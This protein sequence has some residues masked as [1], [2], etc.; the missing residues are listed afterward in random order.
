MNY[1]ELPLSFKC[2]LTAA[3]RL[4]LSIIGRLTWCGGGVTETPNSVKNLASK[5]D[6][7][8]LHPDTRYSFSFRQNHKTKIRPPTE[9]GNNFP[10]DPH[11]A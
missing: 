3:G 7:S 6:P 4:L 8:S 1:C 9:N 5:E 11:H 2:L 10:Q